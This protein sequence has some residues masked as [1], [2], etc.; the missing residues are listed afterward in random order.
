MSKFSG[1]FTAAGEPWYRSRKAEP[2]IRQF[3]GNADHAI[4]YD[5]V[6]NNIPYNAVLLPGDLLS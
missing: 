5:L 2:P 1:N 4:A 3:N 6:P